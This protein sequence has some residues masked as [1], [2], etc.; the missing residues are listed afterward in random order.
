M[1]DVK[2]TLAKLLSNQIR[3]ETISGS[4]SN[5]QYDGYYYRDL[6]V[7]TKNIISMEIISMTNNQSAFCQIV[8]DN[9]IRVWTK[10]AW[11]QFTIRITRGGVLLNSI[12]KAFSHLQTI[13]GGVNA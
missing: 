1:L 9:L 10:L 3:V 11:A 5:A 6:S 13:G 7:N 4:T 2:K 8:T 12:S